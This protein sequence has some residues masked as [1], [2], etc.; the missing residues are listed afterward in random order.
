MAATAIQR[1]IELEQKG[2]DAHSASV[3]TY[4]SILDDFV[5][6]ANEDC[7]KEF[8]DEMKPSLRDDYE[9]VWMEFVRVAASNEE[10]VRDDRLE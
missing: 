9:R 4:K 5:N 7:V 8:F 3:E 1:I 2:W 10:R 6:H